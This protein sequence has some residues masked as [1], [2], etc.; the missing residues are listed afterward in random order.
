MQLI[1]DTTAPRLEFIVPAHNSTGVS[2]DAGTLSAYFRQLNHGANDENIVLLNGDLVFIEDTSGID[3]QNG[4]S[5]DL[6]DGNSRV[7]EV[8]YDPLTGGTTYCLTIMAGGVRDVAGNLKN[9]DIDSRCFTTELDTVVPLLI[10]LLDR[11]ST[12]LNS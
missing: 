6:G 4:A 9:T 1:W 10:S 3:V 5:V 12:S 8:T 11:K 2:T 7:L